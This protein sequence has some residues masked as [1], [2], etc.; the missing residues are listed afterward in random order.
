MDSFALDVSAVPEEEE[1]EQ[2]LRGNVG[3][4]AREP[5]A[6]ERLAVYKYITGN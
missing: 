4:Q 1:V 5:Q 2:S 3:L 6:R